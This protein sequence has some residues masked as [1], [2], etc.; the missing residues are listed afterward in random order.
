[1]NYNTQ[2]IPHVKGSTVY[3]DDLP[4]AKTLLHAVPLLS[5]SAH[6]RF[7]GLDV[8]EAL[9]LHPSVIV[10]TAHDVPGKNELGMIMDDEPLLAEHEWHY[11]GEVLAL[12]LAESRSIA[13]KA[14]SKISI[15]GIEELPAVTDPREAYAQG[16][17]ILSPRVQKSGDTQEAFQSCDIVIDGRVDSGGQEHVYLETQGAIAYPADSGGVRI[18]SG[19]QSPSLVQLA[20]A[21]IL[22]LPMHLVEIETPRL[23]G[24][25][26]GKEE[27]ANAWSALA[28]LGVAVTGRPVKLYLNRR[29]DMLATGKRHPY[30][31]DFTIGL[32][33]DGTIKAFEAVY[34][35]NSGA[36]TDLSPAIIPRTLFHACGAYRIP[37]VK[38]TGIMCRTNL[39]PF[40]A[41][42]GFGGPQ[43]FFVIESAIEAAARTL[44]M[45]PMELRRKNILRTHDHTHY[46]MVLEHA[47][48]EE[49]IQR[50]M[51]L[52]GWQELRAS[53]AAFNKEN[54]R[55]KKGAASIPVCFGIS[56]TKLMMNQGGALVHVYHDGSVSVSTGAVEMGQGVYRKIALLVARCLGIPEH[57]IKVET[58]R[59]TTV[60]NTQP[61]AA[62]TGTDINGAA[63]CLAAEQI[64]ERLLIFSAEL[65]HTIKTE[66]DFMD[67]RLRYVKPS[68]KAGQDTG[69]SFDDIVKKAYESRIDL[70]AHAFYATPDLYYDMQKEYGK[71]F[72][73]H[74][75]GCA[76]VTAT[77][78]TLKA[79]Y[80]FDKAW[81]VHDLAHSIAPDVD[82][83]QIEGAF[84]QG[85]GWSSLEELV[86][87]ADGR[88]LANTLSTYKV[89]DEHFMPEMTVE[90]LD[91]PN[92]YAI[93]NS[94][95]VGEPP[96]MY[97]IAGYF[98][99]Q[100]ALHAA[101][102]AGTL[103]FDLPMTPEKVLRFLDDMV[104]SPAQLVHNSARL[105]EGNNTDAARDASGNQTQTGTSAA[106]DNAVPS[107]WDSLQSGQLGEQLGQMGDTP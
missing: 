17:V 68:D 101:R 4:E 69:Y 26:G 40:T 18:I 62:S 83:G 73:Y 8:S 27:Q 103:F 45:D 72:A 42:R 93:A 16:K 39:V 76:I 30:S 13:R 55:F 86:F 46:G 15:T 11:Q 38:V 23:G 102:P 41:F 70:S 28:A 19:T 105:A 35:Q 58:T 84:A 98:A 81:I 31:S 85:L 91:T 96:L 65:L 49:T 22:G 74:V 78:D 95:A 43:A 2:S 90:I 24:A 32:M 80:K 52:A 20:V 63:A 104:I 56:F 99:V 97:G 71:P 51:K 29:D 60:A 79:T 61:T 88:L 3:I 54:R 66:L 9:K 37:N 89:P 33:K 48:T 67:G 12:V 10:L 1:M 14:V 25:F 77:V 82:R 87:N 7:T 94:K 57:R 21:R 75:Y 5:P 44:G 6:G 34:Y 64:K 36:A 92:P 50:C 47:H 100:D 107:T 53:I 106:S 59:T